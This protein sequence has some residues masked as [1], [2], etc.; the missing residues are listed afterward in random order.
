MLACK[1]LQAVNETGALNIIVLWTDGDP[2]G[3]SADFNNSTTGS[4]IG[5]RVRANQ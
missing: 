4:L 1:E 3:I 2:N 5:E